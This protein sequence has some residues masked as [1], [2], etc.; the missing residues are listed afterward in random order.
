MDNELTK[1]I[2]KF[3]KV[4]EAWIWLVSVILVVT[5]GLV[6]WSILR[7]NDLQYQV[8]KLEDTTQF[9]VDTLHEVD[10][11]TSGWYAEQTEEN[12]RLGDTDICDTLCIEGEEV[13]CVVGE[14]L[15]Q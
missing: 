10:E 15:R 1:A 8:T 3:H 12:C 13:G 7:V 14:G 4:L 5:F 11:R 9:L 2:L 6:V